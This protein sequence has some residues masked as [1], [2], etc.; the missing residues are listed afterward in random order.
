MDTIA[1]MSGWQVVDVDVVV[2]FASMVFTHGGRSSE[3]SAC[4]I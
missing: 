1:R 3:V 4:I 2:L